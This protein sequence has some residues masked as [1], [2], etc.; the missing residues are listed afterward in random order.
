MNKITEALEKIDEE[1]GL[2]VDGE[3]TLNSGTKS[4]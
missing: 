4:D 1:T 3:D 2:N